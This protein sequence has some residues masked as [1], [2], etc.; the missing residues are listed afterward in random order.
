MDE[1]LEAALDILRKY[2]LDKYEGIKHTYETW[3]Y[4]KQSDEIADYNIVEYATD[5]VAAM[6]RG[7]EK[8][9]MV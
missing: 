6:E 5:L 1:K 9:G 8:A 2:F 4:L 7:I 3:E